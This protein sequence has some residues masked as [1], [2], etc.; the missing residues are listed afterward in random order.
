MS[1]YTRFHVKIEI[2]VYVQP[3]LAGLNAPE[4]SELAN[5][6]MEGPRPFVGIVLE[7]IRQALDEVEVI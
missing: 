4:V 7:S 6:E 1:E 3:G 2:G 5:V